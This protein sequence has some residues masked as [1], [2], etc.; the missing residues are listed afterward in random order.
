[1]FHRS[2]D[3][4]RAPKATARTGRVGVGSGPC[5]R[6]S[7]AGDASEP[8]GPQHPSVPAPAQADR[9]PG[10]SSPQGRAGSC[11]SGVRDLKPLHTD[12]S[13]L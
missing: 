2:W 3:E 12:S 9:T 6:T 7:Q 1:M 5:R 8:P 13:D 10:A 4:G 11:D